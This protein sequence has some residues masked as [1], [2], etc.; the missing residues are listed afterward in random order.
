MFRCAGF[1]VTFHFKGV[2]QRSG[3]VGKLTTLMDALIFLQPLSGS[4]GD[5]LA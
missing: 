2:V 3:V 1:D 5:L 4:A